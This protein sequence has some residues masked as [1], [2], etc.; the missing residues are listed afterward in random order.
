MGKVQ[1]R[2]SVPELIKQV[3]KNSRKF[4]SFWNIKWTL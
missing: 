3:K 2:I 1:N 4:Y